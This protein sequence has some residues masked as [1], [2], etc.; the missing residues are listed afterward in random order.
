VY[1]NSPAEAGINAAKELQD[2]WSVTISEYSQP[3]LFTPVIMTHLFMADTS[4][5]NELKVR[6]LYAAF[7]P[8]D[9][10][11]AM[12]WE[13][14]SNIYYRWSFGNHK[15][16]IEHSIRRAIQF[17][18]R[19]SRAYFINGNVLKRSAGSVLETIASW[20][21][22]YLYD[23]RDADPLIALAGLH[24]K[25][26][27]DLRMGG[28]KQM[29]EYALRNKPSYVPARRALYFFIRDYMA[30]K[31]VALELVN[32]GL[33][34][35]QDEPD[36]LMMQAVV[37]LKLGNFEASRTALEHLIALNQANPNAWYNLGIIEKAEK[38]DD[39]ARD[40]FEKALLLNGPRDAH[41]YLG[42]YY[43]M[44]E[45]KEKALYHYRWRW[46]KRDTDEYDFF[47][48]ASQERIRMLVTG[49][50]LSGVVLP[51]WNT[52]PGDTLLNEEKA[53]NPGQTSPTVN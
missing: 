27:R 47:A 8:K 5:S 17:D 16:K 18:D 36:L 23:R 34:L 6:I 25:H 44:K 46:A 45:D 31:A 14:L 12:I 49:K 42:L 37:S 28:N 53:G 51:D 35:N 30:L 2:Y 29:L 26:V 3:E 11:Q 32:E 15:A 33:A 10:A 40:A 4:S 50:S 7:E 43:T 39:A 24:Y 1:G 21:L 20:K 48:A 52:T 9:S 13:E 19:A 41:Y 22:A 38:N